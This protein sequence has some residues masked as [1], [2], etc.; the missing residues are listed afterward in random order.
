MAV[1]EQIARQQ[2]ERSAWTSCLHEFKSALWV[3][4][5]RL[6]PMETPVMCRCD[7]ELL[8]HAPIVSVRFVVVMPQAST[9]HRNDKHS[10]LIDENYVVQSC[11]LQGTEM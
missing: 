7:A 3:T 2:R 10:F 11:M 1:A 9:S 6:S 5:G 4:A 8:V